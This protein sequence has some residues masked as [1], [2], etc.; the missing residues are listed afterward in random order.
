MSIRR[1]AYNLCKSIWSSPIRSQ[2]QVLLQN[3]NTASEEQMRTGNHRAS[4]GAASRQLRAQLMGYLVID[5]DKERIAKDYPPLRWT[6]GLS[7]E[8]RQLL[9][10]I[11][12]QFILL[13]SRCVSTLT[14]LVPECSSA[15]DPYFKFGYEIS[16]EIEEVQL[17]DEEIA[18]AL[19]HSFQSHPAIAIAL[20][21]NDKFKEATPETERP[22]IN[23]IIQAVI[24]LEQ[25][26][27]NSGPLHSP[28]KLWKLS[29]THQPGSA[30]RV[31]LEYIYAL[32]CVRA[33]LDILNEL[34][35]Q[36]L[37]TNKLP[38]LDKNSIIKVGNLTSTF[39]GMG[40]TLK[41]QPNEKS[42]FGDLGL[43]LVK[44]TIHD[45]EFDLCR[46]EKVNVQ[47]SQDFGDTVD[48]SL[49]EIDE[50]LNPY[51]GLL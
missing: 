50:N 38:V 21:S 29:I 28:E 24:N 36:A 48:I 32:V 33:S 49:R 47:V 41:Y 51:K 14:Q 17:Y 39:S 7:D 6:Q 23:E 37:W 25:G 10:K 20:E 16:D 22:P 42:G 30:N 2:V 34:I 40:F 18:Q 1:D 27:L 26:L 35:Y 15:I 19:F 8:E 12:K 44:T 11:H 9:I 3:L 46:A 43:I 13:N 4:F 31:L 45:R 5:R